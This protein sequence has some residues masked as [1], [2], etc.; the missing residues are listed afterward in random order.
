MYDERIH[1]SVCFWTELMMSE[2]CHSE[3]CVNIYVSEYYP[4]IA[5]LV[6]PEFTDNPK[7]FGNTFKETLTLKPEIWEGPQFYYFAVVSL[8][9]KSTSSSTDSPSERSEVLLGTPELSWPSRGFR[10]MTDDFLNR[11]VTSRYMDL[12]RGE[13][14]WTCSSHWHYAE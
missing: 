13:S 6:I 3:S 2:F 9:V 12:Q 14:G 10:A 1:R 7:Q 11:S 4:N 5:S 8:A